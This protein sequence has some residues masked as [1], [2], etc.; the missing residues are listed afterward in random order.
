MK[1]TFARIG[2]LSLGVFLCLVLAVLIA[3]LAQ[4]QGHVLVPLGFVAIVVLLASRYGRA[5]GLI[6]TVVGA[7]VFA[8]LLYPPLHSFRV[9]DATAR[10]NLGWMLLAGLA[11]SHLLLPPEKKPR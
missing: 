1:E 10:S 11:L 4:A 6:G 9:A 5:V 8:Y 2:R 7:L 3:L